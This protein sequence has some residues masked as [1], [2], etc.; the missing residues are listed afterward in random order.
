MRRIMAMLA[1][2]GLMATLWTDMLSAGDKK[3]P[4]I[5]PRKGKTETIKLFNGT[6]LS[7]WEEIARVRHKSG[8]DDSAD[9]SYVTLR[10]KPQN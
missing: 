10:R 3:A 8:P 7:G 5:P 1:A 6:D 9:F 4:E 2:G